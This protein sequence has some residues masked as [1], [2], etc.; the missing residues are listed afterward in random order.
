MAYATNQRAAN[1][2]DDEIKTFVFEGREFDLCWRDDHVL[3][4]GDKEIADRMADSFKTVAKHAKA[5]HANS[6]WDYFSIVPLP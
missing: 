6:A 5:K 2:A 1:H 4:Y 3:V